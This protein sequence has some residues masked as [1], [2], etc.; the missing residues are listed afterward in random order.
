L[1]TPASTG[2]GA[3]KLAGMM[4]LTT[5]SKAASTPNMLGYFVLIVPPKFF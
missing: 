3:A 4:K 5:K 2:D 1:H